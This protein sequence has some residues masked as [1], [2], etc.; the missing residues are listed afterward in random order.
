[1]R[2]I[3][4]RG[5]QTYHGKFVYGYYRLI[6]DDIHVI[7]DNG[8]Q[9]KVDPETVGQFTGLLDKNGVKI[10]EGDIIKFLKW[11]EEGK[12]AFP[13][14]WDNEEARFC[15][16][17]TNYKDVK[18][19]YEDKHYWHLIGSHIELLQIVVIG[20]IYDN[21]EYLKDETA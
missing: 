21:P 2:K 4:F 19:P 20:N 14:V 3:L 6:G 9:E 15:L 12:G 11:E 1:M 10:F 16:D 7:I 17:V 5:I 13:V 8:G 18:Q